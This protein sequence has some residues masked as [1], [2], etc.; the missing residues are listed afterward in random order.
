MCIRA[1]VIRVV[2]VK[3]VIVLSLR[4]PFL[5]SFKG[6]PFNTYLIYFTFIRSVAIDKDLSRAD[7]KTGGAL[8][9]FSG[10]TAMHGKSAFRLQ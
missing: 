2:S 10:S 5:Y 8:L 7:Q 1:E 4:L 9:E 3:L 6:R